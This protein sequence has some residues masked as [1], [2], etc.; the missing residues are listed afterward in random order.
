[1]LNLKVRNSI[2]HFDEKVDSLALKKH[3]KN[4]N[5]INNGSIL[6]NISLSSRKTIQPEP[7]YFI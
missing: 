1:M 2:E 4:E 5:L 6:H 7:Y 3:K